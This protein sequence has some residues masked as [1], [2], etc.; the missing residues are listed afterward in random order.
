MS[1]IPSQVGRYPPYKTGWRTRHPQP[2]PVQSRSSL[3]SWLQGRRSATSALDCRKGGIRKRLTATSPV[4]CRG[5]IA[6]CRARE[7]GEWGEPAD[8]CSAERSDSSFTLD[9]QSIDQPD[10]RES[11][12]TGGPE[13]NHD[14]WRRQ[15]ESGG[16]ELRHCDSA[17][18]YIYNADHERGREI[19]QGA[20]GDHHPRW[21]MSTCA[22][23]KQGQ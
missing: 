1:L 19:H 5:W 21:S 6:I 14:C 17:R 18:T 8:R 20:A 15:V 16:T 9:W 23:I 22:D 12:E 3:C 2:P 10:G 13:P 11:E 4:D 7:V